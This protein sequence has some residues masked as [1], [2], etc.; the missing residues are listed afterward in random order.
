M[1]ILFFFAPVGD[2]FGSCIF[3]EY[4]HLSESDLEDYYLSGELTSLQYQLLTDYLESG[5]V[6]NNSAVVSLFELQKVLYKRELIPHISAGG[7]KEVGIH[8]QAISLNYKARRTYYLRDPQN[9]PMEFYRLSAAVS[10]KFGGVVELKGNST[11][12]RQLYRRSLFYQRGEAFRVIMGNYYADFGLGLNVGGGDYYDNDTETIYEDADFWQTPSS[13]YNGGYIQMSISGVKSWLLYSVKRYS[14]FRKDKVA[15]GN[16]FNLE[17]GVLGIL[18]SYDKIHPDSSGLTQYAENGGA[19]FS[20]YGKRETYA[21]EISLSPYSGPS[22]CLSATIKRGASISKAYIWKYSRNY[23]NL[24]SNGISD[25]DMDTY[26]F[27]DSLISYLADT[28][29]R[30]GVVLKN[31]YGIA[32]KFDLLCEVAGMGKGGEKQSYYTIAPGFYLRDRD[33]ISIRVILGYGTESY[34]NNPSQIIYSQG[35]ISTALADNYSFKVEFAYRQRKFL[36]DGFK[37][38]PSGKLIATVYANPTAGLKLQ[39]GSALR[40]RVW[41]T[42]ETNYTELFFGESLSLA[43]DTEFEFKYTIR[44]GYGSSTAYINLNGEF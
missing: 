20:Y 3:D 44:R 7:S 30:F 29:N 38:N 23:F 16:E 2:L 13:A 5:G 40:R 27:S 37:P 32:P 33:G 1:I 34:Y 28:R 43:S 17:K 31:Q 4:Y 26:Y 8:P 19:Y 10:D 35:F 18:G 22:F 41:I 39:I 24:S 25:N 12:P 42:A 15:A 14:Q 11:T 36:E 6:D 21:A 9:H